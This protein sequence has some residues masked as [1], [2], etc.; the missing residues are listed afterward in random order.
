MIFMGYAMVQA[1]NHQLLTTKEQ[2][3]SQ[4]NPCGIC[5]AQTDNG[6]GFSLNTL[7]F[8]SVEFHTFSK[9]IQSPIT[10]TM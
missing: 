7:I 4:T 5:G 1:V 6:T 10:D 9:L 2:I 8:P 3:Q